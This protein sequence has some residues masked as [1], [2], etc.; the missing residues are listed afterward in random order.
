MLYS[1]GQLLTLQARTQL[2][3][4]LMQDAQSVD[5]SCTTTQVLEEAF[6]LRKKTSWRIVELQ[7]LKAS[8]PRH[9]VRGWEQTIA[10]LRTIV[11]IKS[12]SASP[13]AKS[14]LT[15]VWMLIEAGTVCCE[16]GSPAD[17]SLMRG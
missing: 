9:Q 4:V 8:N 12:C 5:G 1:E 13:I 3:E 15:Y 7:H 10:D 14:F 11:A 16:H 17:M 6:A 2:A